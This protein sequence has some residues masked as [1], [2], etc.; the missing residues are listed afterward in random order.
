MSEPIAVLIACPTGDT[1]DTLA[2]ALVEAGL[3]ACVNRLPGVRS[4]YRW[5]GEVVTDE[6]DL[7]V[8]KTTRE[9]FAAL[10]RFVLS[11]HP[12]EVPEIVA[13]PMVDGHAAYLA[14]LEASVDAS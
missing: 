7:L 13:L 4:T 2:R 14:W 1:A 3:A 5:K 12:Y 11:R 9:T 8:A 6:E 10:E